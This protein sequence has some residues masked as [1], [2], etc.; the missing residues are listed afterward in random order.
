[1][2]NLIGWAV[3]G[4]V[5]G[6][7]AKLIYPGTQGGGIIATSVLGVVGAFVGGFLYTFITTGKFALAAAGGGSLFS[8][9][10]AVL[11]SMV[12]IFVWGLV[13]QNA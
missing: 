3:L 8:F 11:G 9:I 13:T 7:I 4:L 10:C 6:A 5:A 1:M 2:W 12:V